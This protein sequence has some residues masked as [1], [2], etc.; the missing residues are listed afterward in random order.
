MFSYG[1]E[2]KKTETQIVEGPLRVL[3]GPSIG[4]DD[5]TTLFM[6]VN[7]FG[8][9]NTHGVLVTLSEFMEAISYVYNFDNSLV[10]AAD[11]ERNQS[12]AMRAYKPYEMLEVMKNARDNSTA[13]L[14]AFQKAAR[15]IENALPQF[16]HWIALEEQE[17]NVEYPHYMQIPD[18]DD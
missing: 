11:L 17:R 4:E 5:G 7:P 12:D 3:V 1:D 10:A 18:E 2:E 15:E 8:G 16:N 14:S 6:Q 13:L 9:G